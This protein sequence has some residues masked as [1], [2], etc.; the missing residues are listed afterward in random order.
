MFFPVIFAWLVDLFVF[1]SSNRKIEGG[2]LKN[3]WPD[4]DSSRL[5]NV[6]SLQGSEPKSKM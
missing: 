2:S 4:T 6:Y 5:A 1:I 3:I